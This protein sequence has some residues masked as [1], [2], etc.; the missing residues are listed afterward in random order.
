MSQ[1][2]IMVTQD[3]TRFGGIVTMS[4]DFKNAARRH[5]ASAELLYKNQYWGDADHLYGFAAEC[6]LKAIMVAL[7][8]PTKSDDLKKDSHRRHIDGLWGEYNSF[9]SG[10]N[11]SNY[12]VSIDNPFANW[13]V[14]QRYAGSQYFDNSLVM[15]H[16]E[17]TE[18]LLKLLQQNQI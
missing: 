1:P 13:D 5:Y 17:A 10:R 3:M 9:V 15:P 14:A 4:I 11:Q 12:L 6:L 7:G 8:A 16:R 18:K 2:F